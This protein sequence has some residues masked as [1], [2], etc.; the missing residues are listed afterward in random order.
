MGGVAVCAGRPS[1]YGAGSGLGWVADLKNDREVQEQCRYMV[2]S[3]VI[4]LAE[5]VARIFWFNLQDWREGE[6]LDLGSFAI[7]FP[8][9]AFYG[10]QGEE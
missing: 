5:G 4:A 3:H 6:K 1:Q 10:A 8:A 9:T 2:Q 7:L